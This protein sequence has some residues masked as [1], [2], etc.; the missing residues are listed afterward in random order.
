MVV[1]ILAFARKSRLGVSGE[2]WFAAISFSLFAL[3]S[4]PPIELKYAPSISYR[5]G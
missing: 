2:K 1:W 3:Y 5:G 4:Y